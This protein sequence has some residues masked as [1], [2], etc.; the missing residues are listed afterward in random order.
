[1]DHGAG[2][3]G[4]GLR[5]Q[6]LGPQLVVH[7]PAVRALDP[8][9]ERPGAHRVALGQLGEDRGVRQWSRKHRL[10]TRRDRR[11]SALE[12]ATT[13]RFVGPEHHPVEPM[14]LLEL[15]F[16]PMGTGPNRSSTSSM[17]G[18]RVLGR[19][20]LVRASPR[21]PQTLGG[22]RDTRVEQVPLL[23]HGVTAGEVPV[24]PRSPFLSEEGIRRLG[25]GEVA[26]LERGEEEVPGSR[27][28]DPIRAQHSNTAFGG[29][30][31]SRTSST[32]AVHCR[33]ISC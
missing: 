29:P 3:Q 4:L 6:P 1:M 33:V 21:Q 27:G 32:V 10:D 15:E 16:G 22:P 30:A 7:E 14:D 9:L 31:P 13:R 26:V 5:I 19:P 20:Y 25:P 2:P 12:L 23:Q 17:N 11:D 8:G 18:D 24:Q 28:A